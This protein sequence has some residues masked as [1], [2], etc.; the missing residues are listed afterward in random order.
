[1]LAIFTFGT[2]DFVVAGL[3]RDMAEDLG[4]G[5]AAIGQ[6]V[7]VYSIVYA[8]SAPV[9]AVLTARVPRR[10]LAVAGMAMF[11]AGNVVAASTSDYEVLLVSR[12]ISA[13]AAAAVTPM[14]F[15]AAGTLPPEGRRGRA[16][17]ALSAGIM[18][19]QL[20]GV[21]LGTWFGGMWGWQAA[22]W[23]CVGLGVLVLVTMLTLLPVLALPPAS[24]LRERLAPATKGPVLRGLSAMMLLSAGSMM[25]MTYIAPIS[26]AA[27]GVD[28]AGVAMLFVAAGLAGVVATQVGGAA[29]DKLG[30]LRTV[31]IGAGML[32][33]VMVV[34]S[35]MVLW[36]STPFAALVVLVMFMAFAIGLLNPPLVVW[37]LGRAGPS[38]NEVMA[39]NASAM[40]LGTSLGGV[41]GGLMLSL[42]GPA[43]LPM[44]AVVETALMV[45]LVVTA[46]RD[47]RDAATGVPAER[48]TTAVA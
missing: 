27:G 11:I 47:S 16:L 22:F 17:G 26:A 42:Y 28:T 14:C 46:R 30:A 4:R 36:G 24:G 29:S 20:L 25:M 43:A 19:A 37:L 23:M 44:L 40:Y 12:V 48:E 32:V 41:L 7:T 10:A 1:M 6:L 34:L 35:G 39:L 38:G 3:L 9:A 15:N 33:A 18:L 31:A 13:M 8:I 5:E 45:V 2:A 21:P